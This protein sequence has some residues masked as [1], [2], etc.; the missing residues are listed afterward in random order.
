MAPDE[1][2][3]GCCLPLEILLQYRERAIVGLSRGAF[4]E[5]GTTLVVDANRAR[6]A[7]P[8]SDS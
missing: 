7:D 2:L 5:R 4:H 6:N 1:R 8:V 3:G